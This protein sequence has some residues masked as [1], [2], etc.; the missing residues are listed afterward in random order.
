MA[1]PGICFLTGF[2]C[3]PV[4]MANQFQKN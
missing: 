1:I 3:A 4:F 2:D